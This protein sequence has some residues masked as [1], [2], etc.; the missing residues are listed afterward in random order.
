MY[1]LR[2]AWYNKS[3]IYGLLFEAAAQTLRTIAAD[4]RHLGA[5]IGATLVLHTWGSAFTHHPHVHGIVS[6]GGLSLYGERWVACRPGFF[7]SEIESSTG[8][9]PS[10]CRN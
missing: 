6:G 10:D 1:T 5:Q 9:T 4:P 3:V 2:H 7:L 8:E